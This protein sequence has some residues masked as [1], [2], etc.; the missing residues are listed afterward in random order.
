MLALLHKNPVYPVQI[1]AWVLLIASCAVGPDYQVPEHNP[2][3]DSPFLNA[4]P[5]MDSTISPE[6]AWWEQ[7]ED[8]TLQSYVET[9]LKDNLELKEISERI[10]QANERRIIQSGNYYPSL[11]SNL[12]GSRSAQRFD[13]NN[14]RFYVNRFDT[15]LSVSW[16]LDLFGKIKRSVESAEATLQ[17][18]EA[19]R[20]ALIHSLIADLANRRIGISI[21]A[22]LLELA[23]ENATNQKI[24]YELIQR[25]Y[26]LGAHNTAMA[27]VHLAEENYARVQ[28]EIPGFERLLSNELYQ[29]DVLLG[30]RPG[31]TNRTTA[32]SFPLITE[33]P[34][35]PD[36]IPL[37]LLDR[38]PDLRASE[39]RVRAANADIGVAI[40]DLYP[41]LNLSAG[42]GFSSS[43]VEDLLDPDQM[44]GSLVGSIVQRFFEGGALRA[45]IRLQESEM[46]ELA[47]NYSNAIL[48]AI[49]EVE[50]ALKADRELSYQLNYESQTVDALKA[51]EAIAETR[52]QQGLQTLQSFLETRQRRY[53]AE[54]SWLRTQQLRWNTRI[55]LYLALGGTIAGGG[56]QYGKHGN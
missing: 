27:D 38:R 2:T 17:A 31:Y 12:R 25:R 53:Q 56:E 15:D 23:R 55:S 52:Y 50:T 28:S 6:I 42:I 1:L 13:I 48:N 22:R 32:A 34:A 29:L 40:A 19:E 41:S 11:G 7:I 49:R 16:Q 46:R 51:A 33:P 8:A 9:L 45:T 20:D 39:L 14:Q 21:N 18:T 26:N 54:Q 30:K 44:V 36:V 10:F 3:T 5:E 47:L 24:L 37:N 35:I 43:V 4:D